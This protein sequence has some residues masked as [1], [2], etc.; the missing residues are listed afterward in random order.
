M[1]DHSEKSDAELMLEREEL[2]RAEKSGGVLANVGKGN[3]KSWAD[4]IDGAAASTIV[5]GSDQD[6]YRYV[7]NATWDVE[8]GKAL[9]VRGT[10]IIDVAEACNIGLATVRFV[11][12]KYHWREERRHLEAI[13]AE[14]QREVSVQGNRALD[15]ALRAGRIEG[16]ESAA[17]KYN[18]ELNKSF[19]VRMELIYHR[20]VSSL[21]GDLEPDPVRVI[22]A[23]DAGMK[24]LEY[25]KAV[26][27]GITDGNNATGNDRTASNEPDDGQLEQAASEAR[28]R[29]ESIEKATQ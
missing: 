22:K 6:Y 9:Y 10:R 21:E 19:A 17:H 18:N 29:I 13:A 5:P 15:A 3:R 23:L 2:S 14:Q 7:K 25:Q 24:L 4:R 20:M 12:G 16:A 27:Q 28:A 8:A 11:S 1:V 26:R